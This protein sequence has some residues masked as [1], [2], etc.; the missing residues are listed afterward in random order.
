V[1]PDAWRTSFVRIR[2]AAPSTPVGCC[3]RRACGLWRERHSW[4][5]SSPAAASAR[6]SYAALRRAILSR[7]RFSN[8]RASVA[9]RPSRR[10]AATARAR[11]SGGSTPT[12]SRCGG[13]RRSGRARG[14]G[15]VAGAARS[16]ERTGRRSGAQAMVEDSASCAR[17][18][19]GE[20]IVVS[21]AH[22]RPSR[23]IG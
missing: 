18:T 17:A 8:D 21:S 10:A 19:V 12:T 7:A 15:N 1:P 5:C 11:R 23:L 14:H 13:V 2:A 4:R 22:S 6:G 9:G 3:R 16:G 20:V